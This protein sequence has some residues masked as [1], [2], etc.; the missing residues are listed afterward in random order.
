MLL[1]SLLKPNTLGATLH[2]KK[3]EA[4]TR[5][6]ASMIAAYA[7][8]LLQCMLPIRSSKL[9]NAQSNSQQTWQMP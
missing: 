2:E 4:F 8:V 7:A 9:L 5:T 1:H 3:H 6:I